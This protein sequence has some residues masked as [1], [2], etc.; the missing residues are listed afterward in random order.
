MQNKKKILLIGG[1]NSLLG[2][3]IFFFLKEKFFILRTSRK[4]RNKLDLTNQILVSKVLD[5]T[6]PDIIINCS[7][8]TDVDGCEK[9]PNQAIKENLLSNINLCEAYELLN[10]KKN[11]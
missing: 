10:K 6:K 3:S 9:N 4:K 1:H 11:I 7:G 8:Y 2:S 5:K